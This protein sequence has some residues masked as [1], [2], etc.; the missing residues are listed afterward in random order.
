MIFR[1]IVKFR[2]EKRFLGRPPRLSTSDNMSSAVSS[3]MGAG[4]EGSVN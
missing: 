2:T 4:R 1:G 3:V